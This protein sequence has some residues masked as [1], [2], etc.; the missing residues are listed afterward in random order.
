MHH[1]AAGVLELH[2]D[3]G[4][5]AFAG[6]LH[7]VG[8]LVFPHPVAQGGR[9]LVNEIVAGAR[10]ACGQGH[11]DHVGIA[12]I[13][14][15]HVGVTRLVGFDDG[16]GAGRHVVE[17][18]VAVGIGRGGL[19]HGAG[20]VLELNG[21]ASD[22]GVAAVVVVQ[23]FTHGT[24]DG[25]GVG[26]DAG[27][28]GLVRFARIQNGLDGLAGG[29]VSVAVHTVGARILRG[30][31][32][33]G[34]QRGLVE[35]HAVGAR[36][37][38]GEEVVAAGVGGLGGD[39]VARCIQQRHLDALHAGFARVL[40]AVLVGVV[41]DLVAQLGQLVQAGIHVRVV[42]TG[43]QGHRGRLAGG[44]D[45]AVGHFIAAQVL[46]GDFVAGRL[47]H[48]HRV[49]A[50]GDGE[51]VVAVGVG[52]RALH[53]VAA[54]VLELHGDV[55]NAGFACILNAV[56]VLVFPHPV[57]QG[58]RTLI[59]EVVAGA[60][61]ARRQDHR[62]HVGVATIHVAYVGV[63]RLVGLDDGV[64]AGRHVVEGVVA[65]GVGGGGLH[66]GAGAVLQLY[67]HARDRNIAGVVVVLI[68]SH[69]ARDGTG[70]G[71]DAGV[72]GQVRFARYQFGLDG[73][74]VQRVRV[75][76]GAI[77]TGIG[78]GKAIAGRQ[79]GRIEG[80]AIDTRLQTGEQIVAICIGGDRAINGIAVGVEQAN[81]D[82][83]DTG[84]ARVL[85]TV[86]VDVEPHA[87]ADLGGAIK[88]GVNGVV[89]VASSDGD[90]GT[91]A[92]AVHIAIDGVIGTHI[93]LR[94]R[95]AGGGDNGHEVAAR[96]DREAV[97]AGRIGGGGL[98]QIALGI[99]QLDGH[100]ANAGFARVLQAVTVDVF[101]HGVAD[102]RLGGR[103][104]IEGEGIGGQIQVIATTA[105][106]TAG[107]TH[108]E[109]ETNGAAGIG[110]GKVGE[111]AGGHIGS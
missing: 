82:A 53:H 110:R 34:G 77:G 100:T 3:V 36:L 13:H 98:H 105:I 64:G 86:A 27:V 44:V 66:H 18:V 101:P 91:T 12:T 43:L 51:A 75:G 6:I 63:T 106:G 60:G 20:A 28:P 111:M 84:L 49:G 70:I 45:V 71:H 76:V 19:H 85:H 65:V 31:H 14:V 78:G 56:G 92:G 26:H 69:G 103:R 52:G 109:G 30:E 68:F 62:D 9:T 25:T 107:V 47:E 67:G 96:I 94:R 11:G 10:R 2:G 74:A 7:A 79:G 87:I 1:V 93:R 99:A 57:A 58:G 8:V 32:V 35:L 41:P 61:R 48:G 59:H 4:N 38:A 39:H 54:G 5:A 90:G 16:V 104:D 73:G 17:R 42:L 21:H 108:L 83:L 89:D 102:D 88:A 37:Q 15:A 23:V 72:P 55:G 33:A 81:L 95:V 24:G 40:H 80:D 46:A 22:R 97:L 50:R 29:G